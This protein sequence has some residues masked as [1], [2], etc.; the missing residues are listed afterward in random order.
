MKELVSIL[1]PCYNHEKYIDDCM[2][3]LYAQ[4]YKNIELIISD[5]CSTDNSYEKLMNWKTRLEEK[6]VNVY[7]KKNNINQGITKNLNNMLNLANGKYIK[8]LASDDMLV[9]S[10]IESFVSYAEKHLADIYFSNVALV[11][12]REHYNSIKIEEFRLRYNKNPL[13]GKGIT[14]QLC[15]ENFISAPGVMIPKRTFDVYG[16]FDE[17]YIL[18]DLEYWLRVSVDGSFDYIDSITAM[19]RQND[20]SLSRFDSS[21]ESRKRH[22]KYHN[23]K[24]AIFKKYQKYANESQ[25]KA[26]YNHE[27]DSSIGTNDKTLVNELYQEMKNR[28]I[29]IEKYNLFKAGLVNLGLYPLFKRVKDIVKSRVC[30]IG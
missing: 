24:L 30:K 20:N 1:I 22:R 3:S 18:E 28:K 26:F 25:E 9:S 4:T 27:L 5:D 13:I 23:D 14:G 16:K 12:E 10:A 6:F 17:C 2:E 19:Y 21:E 29:S 11:P 7:I 15:A 8:V